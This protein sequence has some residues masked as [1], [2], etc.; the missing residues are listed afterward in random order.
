MKFSETPDLT[1]TLAKQGKL[2]EA[3]H[4][5]QK[6]LRIKPSLAQTQVNLG[7]VYV[8]Q[9]KLVEAVAHFSEALRIKPD[10]AEAYNNLRIALKELGNMDE[11]PADIKTP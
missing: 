11:M 4:H 7:L 2:N 9:E 5:F 8:R 6:A 10:Y 3:L 1:I